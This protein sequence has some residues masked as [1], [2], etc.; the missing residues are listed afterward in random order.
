[1]TV[2]LAYLLVRVVKGL[3]HAAGY[4]TFMT[5]AL[6]KRNTKVYWIGLPKD[7]LK[8]FIEFALY[9]APLRIRKNYGA[10]YGGFN[11]DISEVRD[12]E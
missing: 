11:Y 6:R 2:G 9:G 12:D 8:R 5:H 10:W 3:Y 1:M 4:C 7:F